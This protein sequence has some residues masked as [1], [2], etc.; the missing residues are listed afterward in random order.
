MEGD[1]L[2]M[3]ERGLALQKMVGNE[4]EYVG[5]KNGQHDATNGKEHEEDEG[6]IIFRCSNYPLCTEGFP[7]RENTKEKLIQCPK[8]DCGKSTNIY[9]KLKRIQVCL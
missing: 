8:E 2:Y 4:G 5:G 3:C 1:V 7:L 6:W 9:L